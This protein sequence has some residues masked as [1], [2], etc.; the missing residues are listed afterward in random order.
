MPLDLFTTLNIVDIGSLLVMH[1]GLLHFTIPL[2]SSG[3]MT[4]FFS[5]T[6]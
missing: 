2:S 3:V 6:S 4:S 5:T 1:F